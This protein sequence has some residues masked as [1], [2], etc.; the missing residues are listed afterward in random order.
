MWTNLHTKDVQFE[1]VDHLFSVFSV[2]LCSQIIKM[3]SDKCAFFNCTNTRRNT[4]NIIF[5][6]FPSNEE[7]SKKW[8]INCGNQLKFN[9]YL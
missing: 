3:S 2:F 8:I 1:L 5:H 9:I 6:P 4:S 7:T